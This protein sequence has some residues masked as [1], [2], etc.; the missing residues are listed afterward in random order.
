MRGKRVAVV[1]ATSE[2]IA[3][4]AVVPGGYLVS[5]I[6]AYM[7]KEKRVLRNRENLSVHNLWFKALETK[8]VMFKLTFLIS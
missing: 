5:L 1:P 3:S 6:T 8:L 2:A 7:E 4:C